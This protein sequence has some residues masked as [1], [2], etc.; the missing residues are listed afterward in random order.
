MNE[1]S[2]YFVSKLLIPCL[3]IIK[4]YVNALWF[5]F[6]YTLSLVL[7]KNIYRII[8]LYNCKPINFVCYSIRVWKQDPLV[9]TIQD[10]WK[11]TRK[12]IF[13][14]R[15]RSSNTKEN[16]LKLHIVVFFYANKAFYQII[17]NWQWRNFKR[18][19]T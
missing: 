6:L 18:T 16:V 5:A 14:Q 13:Y 17:S 19:K 2:N 10:D 3:S 9:C 4:S 12:I 15:I 8:V 1:R 7:S 11:L